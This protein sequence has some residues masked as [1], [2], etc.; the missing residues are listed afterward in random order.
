MRG[1]VVYASINSTY[2]IHDYTQ[3]GLRCVCHGDGRLTAYSSRIATATAQTSITG[4]KSPGGA[5]DV[6]RQTEPGRKMGRS[7]GAGA[8]TGYATLAVQPTI[9]QFFSSSTTV[10]HQ[11]MVSMV[12][13]DDDGSDFFLGEKL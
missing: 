13:M 6:R 10:W 5:R 3:G 8:Y 9:G 2:V 4:C 7:I 11:A 12:L 1:P